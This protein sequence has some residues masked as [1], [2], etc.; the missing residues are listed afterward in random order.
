RRNINT[1]TPFTVEM[2]RGDNPP[3]GAVIYYNVSQ[4]VR[5]ISMDVLDA[6][7]E[8]VR[9]YSSDPIPAIPEPPPPVPDDWMY[10]P[11]PMPTGVGMH[12]IN[13]DMRYEMPPA[14]IHYLA[15]VTGAIPHDT[16]WG[17]EGPL[18]QPGI[19]TLRFNVDGKVST[20]TVT[21]KKELNSP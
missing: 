10:V 2:P 13:W 16:H 5:H 18:V 8:L 6:R 14:F 3:E 11:Q 17:G 9:H 4:A 19:F 15:H 1:G 7:G 12:R 20:Q 21:V